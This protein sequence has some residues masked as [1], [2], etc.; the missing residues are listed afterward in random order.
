[1]R[2]LTSHP[3]VEIVA[4]ASEKAP[5]GSA[6]QTRVPLAGYRPDPPINFD[7][8]AVDADY[9]FL[10]PRKPGLCNGAR[11]A[12][13]KQTKV[14]DLSADFR[15]GTKEV[16]AATY[17]RSGCHPAWP[18]EAGIRSLAGSGASRADP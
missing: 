10:L 18:M 15:L 16:Y 1:M 4:V 8:G 2:L 13:L 14:I 9:V 3:D 5:C 12:L 6:S 11:T 17:K 7:P